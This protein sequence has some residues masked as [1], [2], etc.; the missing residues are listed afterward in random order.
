MKAGYRAAAERLAAE[1]DVLKR[2]EARPS[3]VDLA[4]QELR[5]RIR[6]VEQL[7][8]ENERIGGRSRDAGMADNL[9]FL[10]DTQ[11]P[12]RKV[13]VWAHN[14][15]IGRHAAGSQFEGFMGSLVGGRRPG[16]LYTV[17]FY[18]GWG[19]AAQNDRRRYEIRR[20][21]DDTLEAVLAN[22]GWRLSFVD[23]S[24]ASAGSWARTRVGSREWGINPSA[25]VPAEV[26]D[27]LIYIDAVTPPEYL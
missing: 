19:I 21:D 13:I 20:A 16:E 14:G 2:L 5:S 7:A 6:Y 27:A 24:G 18:M 25:I 26:Y 22:G 17:G 8:A 15:H 23:L 12:G 10:L 1:R 11:Y 9:D 4:I 3:V